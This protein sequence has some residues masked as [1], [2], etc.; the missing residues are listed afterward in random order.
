MTGELDYLLRIRVTG[1]PS[2]DRFYQRLIDKVQIADVSA[3]YVMVDVK[4]TTAL[5][6]YQQNSLAYYSAP[7]VSDPIYATPKSELRKELI[8]KLRRKH[9]HRLKHE[10]G[11]NA[12]T[13]ILATRN[14]PI[15]YL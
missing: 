11:A 6:M 12:K 7:A 15:A 3:S 9:L 1:V 2:Y 4:K 13:E 10:R 5:P 14:S 8:A